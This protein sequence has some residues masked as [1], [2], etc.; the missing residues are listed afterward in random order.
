MGHRKLVEVEEE[1]VVICHLMGR[2]AEEEEAKA[3]VEVGM[4]VRTRWVKEEGQSQ[5]QR[6]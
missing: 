3:E 5:F 6:R 4:W 2:W 1:A